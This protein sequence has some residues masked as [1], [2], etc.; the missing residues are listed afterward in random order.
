MRLVTLRMR[1]DCNNKDPFLSRNYNP[2]EI[3]ESY[4]PLPLRRQYRTLLMSRS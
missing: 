1:I 3:E 4:L 2:L